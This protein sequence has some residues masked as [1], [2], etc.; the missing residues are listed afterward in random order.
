VTFFDDWPI[1]GVD[2]QNR[3]SYIIP[4]T[5]IWY[6]NTSWRIWRCW[7]DN[8]VKFTKLILGIVG[9]RIE[10]KMVWEWYHTRVKA[11]RNLLHLLSI[12]TRELLRQRTCLGVRLSMN[13]WC[14]AW[15]WSW[16]ILIIDLIKWF[17]KSEKPLRRNLS[18]NF[19]KWRW[20]EIKPEIALISSLDDVRKAPVI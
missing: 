11:G 5:H 10:G 6:D 2:M 8:V 17:S 4:D 7:N 18:Y 15:L 13:N 9:A 1:E 3:G 14:L 20:I 12:S 16:S 19:F